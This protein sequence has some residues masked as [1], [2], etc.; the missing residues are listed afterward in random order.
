MTPKSAGKKWRDIKLALYDRFGWFRKE[1][2][3][4][5]YNRR[6]FNYLVGHPE[7]IEGKIGNSECFKEMMFWNT[8]GKEFG[9]MSPTVYFPKE[10]VKKL[11]EPHP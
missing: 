1:H 4:E 9:T 7:Y 11:K 5:Y 3:S 6:H 2:E 8:T 10:W